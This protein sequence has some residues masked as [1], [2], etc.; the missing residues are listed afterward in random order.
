MRRRR[1]LGTLGVGVTAGLAG[2][3]SLFRTTTGGREPPLV[4]N[5]PAASYVPT[6]H[7]GMV[8]LGT[9]DAG[10]LRVALTYSYPHRFWVVEQE[11]NGF[12]ARRIDVGADDAIH[13]MATVWD[14]ETGM[15][16]PTTG[17]TVEVTNADGFLQQEVVYSMLSQRMG[18]HYGGNFPLDGDGTYTAQVQVGGV[19]A[20]R[21]GAFADRFG[22]PATAEIEFAYTEAER[23]DIPYQRYP[24]TQGQ[25][26]SAPAMETEAMP[27]GRAAD[28]PGESLGSGTSGDARFR[29]SRIDA[30][31]FGG[32]YLAV[33][34]ATPYHEFALPGM[35]LRATVTRDGD[36]VSAGRLE[37]ALDP[38][39]GFH[40][41]ASV[42]ALQA[43]D[44]VTL[45]VATPPVAARHEGYET[46]F[47]E[48]PD[49][50][51]A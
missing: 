5:R 16:I 38:D 43:G 36:E 4:E 50:T 23:N 22:E 25:R 32:P 41:G 40:Y 7:E 27:L 13:L 17:V 35:G 51:L 11:E 12:G 20:R 2:C 9:A 18:V 46:A 6:H 30:E 37:P 3:S 33:T 42:A 14:A 21:F 45:S 34:A 44:T 15:V 24:D 10:D 8:M 39:A 49:V 28:L 19:S 48:M 47:L 29:A 26:G 31:R 1:L